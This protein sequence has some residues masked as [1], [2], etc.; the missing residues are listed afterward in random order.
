MGKNRKRSSS[1]PSQ[2]SYS[3]SSDS[4]HARS[5]SY[6]EKK[7]DNVPEEVITDTTMQKQN[8]DG[9]GVNSAGSCEIGKEVDK[10]NV[11]DDNHVEDAKAVSDSRGRSRKRS[12]KH[13]KDR[14][15]SSNSSDSYDKRRKHRHRKHSR[16]KDRK[17]HRRKKYSSS[18][19]DESEDSSSSDYSRAHKHHRRKR[20]RKHRH[21]RHQSDEEESRKQHRKRRKDRSKHRD[22]KNGSHKVSASCTETFGKYGII[23]ESDFYSQRRNFDAWMAEVKQIPSFTGPK[24]ELMEY[25]KEFKED[26]NTA[27]LPDKKYYNYDQWEMDEYNKQKALAENKGGGM[28]SDEARH[29]QEMKL[30]REEKD[31]KEQDIVFGAM[32][33]DKIEEMKGQTRLKREMEVAFRMGDQDKVKRLQRRLEPDEKKY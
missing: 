20:K 33:K 18:S 10:K 8:N 19:S 1:S 27:T 31:K 32:S 15:M 14:S 5:K 29:L 11:V 22:D 23:R 3:S 28:I 4:S 30:R 9:D 7:G 2:S 24:Y 25:F 21:D 26:Y 6:R 13:S 12:S 17:R 16:S